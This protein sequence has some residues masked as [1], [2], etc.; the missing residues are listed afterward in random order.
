M[1]SCELVVIPASQFG[2]L[3]CYFSID[4]HARKYRLFSLKLKYIM[5]LYVLNNILHSQ[6]N[7]VTIRIVTPLLVLAHWFG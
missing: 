2:Y 1:G 6:V 4:Y 5:R 7:C 3:G